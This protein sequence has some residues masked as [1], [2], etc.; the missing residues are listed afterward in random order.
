ML[1]S[2]LTGLLFYLFSAVLVLSCFFA[3]SSKRS[4]HSVLF[5]VLAFFACAWVFL[6]NG[7]EFIAMMLIIIYVGAI[8]VL[9]LFVVM[10]LEEPNEDVKKFK[11]GKLNFLFSFAIGAVLFVELFAI[12]LTTKIGV[13]ALYSTKSYSIQDV[14]LVL[15]TQYFFEFQTA[16]L[17]FFT[18][19]V[20]AIMLTLFPQEE[21]KKTKRQNFFNQISRRKE[22]TI[23]L[24]KPEIGKGIKIY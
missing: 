24:A 17:L 9:F 23:F 2:S 21:D 14:G 7:A 20:G 5:L 3:V 15:Y 12:L 13:E 16:G 4:V 10:M 19:M 22:E 6:T 11:R 18:S 1:L 8:A